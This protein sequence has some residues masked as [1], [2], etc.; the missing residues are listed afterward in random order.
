MRSHRRN[1]RATASDPAVTDSRTSVRRR[2]LLALGA[3]GAGAAALAARSLSG[4]APADDAANATDQ[5][6]GYQLTDHVKRYY[7]TTK[8]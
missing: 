1:R 6:K 8:I 3:G 2:F 5:S 7:G 4:V